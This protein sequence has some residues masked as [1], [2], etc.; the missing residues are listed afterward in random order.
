M[1][2]YKHK[3]RD[4]ENIGGLKTEQEILDFIEKLK[5]D[6]NYT[7]IT[8]DIELKNKLN[9]MLIVEPNLSDV[10]FVLKEFTKYVDKKFEIYYDNDTRYNND[11]SDMLKYKQNQ[12]LLRLLSEYNCGNIKVFTFNKDYIE[13]DEFINNL[14]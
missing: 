6:V 5:S 1:K 8:D 3:Y 13:Y 12:R 4:L 11:D 10:S 14:K 7:F 9:N 2:V